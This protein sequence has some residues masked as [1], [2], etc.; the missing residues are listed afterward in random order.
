MMDTAIVVILVLVALMAAFIAFYIAMFNGIQKNLIRIQEAESQIDEALRKKFDILRSMENIINEETDLEQ[1][2][3]VEFDSEEIRMSN[4]DMDRKLS[5]VS[6][7][8][9]KI[10]SDYEDELDTETFRHLAVDLKIIN[11]KNEAAKA[12]YNKFTTSLN[13]II[14]KFPSNLIARI[15]GIE[16]HL[17]FDNKNMND[18]DIFDFKI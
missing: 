10:K 4:F 6:E 11:E 2:N 3:F 16:P 1:K 13:M 15:H 14:K 5:K 17:Y 7:T 8:F 12:Y 18:D 9:R